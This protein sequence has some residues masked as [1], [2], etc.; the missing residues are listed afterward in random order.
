MYKPSWRKARHE[1]E[2][3]LLAQHRRDAWNGR[4]VR[5]KGAYIPM[6]AMSD[7]DL[8][9]YTRQ[10]VVQMAEQQINRFSRVESIEHKMRAG[11]AL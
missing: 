11:E 2:A 6:L 7:A 3:T 8:R 5:W 1:V 9:L 4:H 10:V